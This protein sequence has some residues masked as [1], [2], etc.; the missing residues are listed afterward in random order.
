MCNHKL[1][2]SKNLA[3]LK[4]SQ[5]KILES[6][7]EY[8]FDIDA[9]DVVEKAFLTTNYLHQKKMEKYRRNIIRAI[10]AKENPVNLIKDL[11]AFSNRVVDDQA[12]EL[13]PSSAQGYLF[14]A[15]QK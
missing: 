7:F 8:H 9:V 5:N 2:F 4:P 11:I 10:N 6:L 3:K 12:E 15:K 13:P 14:F 1:Y